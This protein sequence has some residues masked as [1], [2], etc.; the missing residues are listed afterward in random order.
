MQTKFLRWLPLL[1]SVIIMLLAAGCFQ[2]AGEG[3][4][5]TPIAQALPSDTPFPT[6]T[7]PPP[8]TQTP[9]PTLDPA[10]LGQGGAEDSLTV[11]ETSVALLPL[12]QEDPLG[13]GETATTEYLLQIEPLYVTA[14]AFILGATQTVAFQETATAQSIFPPTFTP[15]PTLDTFAPTQT[16][17]PFIS[18]ADCVH[19]VR[20]EDR[21]L[22]RI[23]LRYGSTVRD[24]AQASGIVNVNLITIGQRLVI[25]RCGTLGVVPP[26]TSTPTG[27]S[28]TTS[29]ST[30]LSTTGTVGGRI[31]VVEQGETLFEISL[32][33]GVA[34]NSIAAAN[35][36][37][38][39]NLIYLGQELVIP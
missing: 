33:Y 32:R 36:I 16:V 4:P 37:T 20:A 7:Q 6:N 23:S 30:A 19:E 17:G 27:Q 8:P 10:A 22:W 39:I 25:P 11:G 5:I 15:P 24:I 31:H 14:T 2:Q 29:G 9:E 38:N 12:G 3:V 28:L 13:L 1:S 18:G 34:V 35:G 21:N 26:P